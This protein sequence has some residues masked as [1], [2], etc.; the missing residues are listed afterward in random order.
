[1]GKVSIGLRGWRFEEEHVFDEDGEVRDIGEMPAETRHRVVRLPSL[2][3][4]PCSACWLI[5]GE[6]NIEECNTGSIVYGEPLAE[7]LL[8][9]DHEADFL[10]WFRELGGSE[11]AGSADLQDEFHE[12]FLDGGRAPE[13]Y[14]G[15]EHVQHRAGDVPDGEDDAN[16]EAVED[17]LEEMEEAEREALDVNLEDL[18]L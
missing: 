3:G 8:C 13:G 2:M 12:W 17:Q 9:A 14:G 1:M 4:E 7:V 10:Y 15:L 6:E 5:H 16:V 11:H 18:D